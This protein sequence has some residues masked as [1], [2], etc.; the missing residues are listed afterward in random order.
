MDYR[1]SVQI[2]VR[3][4]ECDLQGVVNNAVYLNYYEH[5]RHLLLKTLDIDFAKEAE[6]GRFLVVIRIEIDY[7]QSLKSGDSVKI[8]TCVKQKGRCRFVFFQTMTNNADHSLVSHAEVTGV[9]VQNGRPVP[10]PILKE[11]L[12]I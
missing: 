8:D 12:S 2:Q 3:D 9:C 5:A 6:N 10:Y 1:H 7:K 11:K 4:Y